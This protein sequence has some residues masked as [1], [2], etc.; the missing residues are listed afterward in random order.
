MLCGHRPHIHAETLESYSTK[1]RRKRVLLVIGGEV[2]N[3]TSTMP[4]NW[5]R[6]W[7]RMGQQFGLNGKVGTDYFR[8]GRDPMP[9]SLQQHTVTQGTDHH[10][11]LDLELIGRPEEVAVV[12][13]ARIHESLQ[14]FGG[15]M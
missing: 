13:V 6:G 8:K 12:A 3:S 10:P 11:A 5:L 9:G 4:P 14:A 2:S 7:T 15:R 1:V